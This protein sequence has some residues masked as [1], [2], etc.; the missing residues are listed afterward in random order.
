LNSNFTLP[1]PANH[2]TSSESMST[3]PAVSTE[4]AWIVE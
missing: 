1:S 3:V 4:N 2:I